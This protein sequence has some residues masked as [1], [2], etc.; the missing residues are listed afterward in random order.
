M[1]RF[2]C[3]DLSF[4]VEPDGS[5]VL[6]CAESSSF[7]RM[8]PF[9]SGLDVHGFLKR[10]D[11]GLLMIPADD[12]FQEILG[13]SAIPVLTNLD[14]PPCEPLITIL[15][16]RAELSFD[17]AG[18]VFYILARIEEY[19]SPVRDMY[20]CFP[21][22]A[23]HSFRHGYLHR[24]VVDELIEILWS[25]LNHLWPRLE[26]KK[27][28]FRTMVSHDVDRPFEY[29]FRSP[30]RTARIFGGDI[31]KRRNPELA[32]RRA[33]KWFEVRQKG[34]EYDPFYTFDTIMDISESHD[35]R[36]AFYFFACG[37]SR[38]DGEYDI[39]H[40]RII[41]LMKRIAERGHEI[42]Y[43][44]SYCTYRNPQ[45]TCSEVERLGKIAAIH[46]I[47]QDAWGGRQHYLRWNAPVTWRNYESAGLQYDTSLSYI[48]CAGFRCGTCHPFPVF[49]TEQCTTLNL[50]EYP[51]IV[52]E[53]SVF[54][55]T[56]MN[57][58]REEG[59]NYI[60]GLK[61]AC[62]K[63]K[64]CFTLLWHN[65][66]FVDPLEVDIYKRILDA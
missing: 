14:E 20:D 32:F 12:F 56:L 50:H 47:E 30:W 61:D 28:V 60:K 51:L 58:P 41:E 25:C 21:A 59:F 16:D 10:T 40:P 22:A 37:K 65:H 23:S 26:R 54:H 49:D 62:R 18:T 11:I 8:P 33:V 63:Y 34:N 24:P 53:C 31:L 2:G 66:C 15:Q 4:A 64:G 7:L 3:G 17:L 36:S 29:L 57:M 43:H 55:E 46:G 52:M 27:S 35:I 45:K 13:E 44:G 42:G 9:L 38:F 6:R 1:E 5:L 39:A 19:L 48:D